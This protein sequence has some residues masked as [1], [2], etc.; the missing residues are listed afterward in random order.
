MFRFKPLVVRVSARTI[1]SSN[2]FATRRSTRSTKE[3]HTFRRSTSSFEKWLGTKG[4][5]F[6]PCSP[7]PR[8]LVAEER[9]GDAFVEERAKLAHALSVMQDSMQTALGRMQESVYW[10]GLNANR[11]LDSLA[12]LLIAYLLLDQAVTANEK[13]G[14]AG[15]S[16][17]AFYRGKVA[18]A[19]F[20]AS[21]VLPKLDMRLAQLK[22]SDLSLMDMDESAF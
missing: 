6:R 10:V 15:E 18:S 5:L 21:T 8:K 14:A 7:T 19:R 1:P 4:R 13:L 20:F 9:G 2:T 17:S 22:G 12:E 3:R 16:D 11:L